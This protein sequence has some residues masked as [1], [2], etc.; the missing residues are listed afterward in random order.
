LDVKN[1]NKKYSIEQY[2]AYKQP[3]M[4]PLE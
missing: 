3:K 4:K 1:K 2:M